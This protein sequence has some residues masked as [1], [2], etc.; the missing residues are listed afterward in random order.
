MT[1]EAMGL[2][3][4][5][6]SPISNLPNDGL[7]QKSMQQISVLRFGVLISGVGDNLQA[8]AKKL[9]N[10][11]SIVL[12][13]SSNASAIG[14]ARAEEKGIQ[15]LSLSDA[16]YDDPLIADQVIAA[17]FRRCKADYIIVD[18]YKP[19]L[20]EG[21]LLSFPYK[22]LCAV[23]SLFPGEPGEDV[24]ARDLERGMKMSGVTIC[25]ETLGGHGPIIAQEAVRI[26]EGMT[27]D[28]LET[29]I[30]EVEHVLYPQVIELLAEGRVQVDADGRVSIA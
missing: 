12:V 22:V 5:I 29:A 27:R 15:T 18:D 17:E 2:N 10:E 28:E 11:C 13:I 4:V 26:E 20:K 9:N 14:L 6:S 7:L 30:H 21:L 16:L 24:I 19:A 23:P 8:I 25:F 1:G 3:G